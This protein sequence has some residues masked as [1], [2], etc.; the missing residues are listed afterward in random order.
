MECQICK[1]SKHTLPLN[2][3]GTW[4][5]ACEESSIAPKPPI[6]WAYELRY[7]PRAIGWVLG[8][9]AANVVFTLVYFELWYRVFGS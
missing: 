9:I 3:G 4:C 5:W 6:D 8:V 2:T 1:S 7:W